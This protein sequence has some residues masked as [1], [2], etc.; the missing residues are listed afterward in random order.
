MFVWMIG[1]YNAMRWAL[2]DSAENLGKSSCLNAPKNTYLPN[3]SRIQYFMQIFSYF[4]Q[5]SLNFKIKVFICKESASKVKCFL[6]S[7]IL[8]NRLVLSSQN[9]LKI[10]LTSLL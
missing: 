4:I 5:F 8:R 1:V 10:I 9:R 6:F 7:N 2:K 3:C